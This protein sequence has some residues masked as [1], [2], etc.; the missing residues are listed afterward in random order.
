VTTESLAASE[1]GPLTYTFVIQQTS[2]LITTYQIEWVL[3]GPVA[4][5][6]TTWG[7]IKALYR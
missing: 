4:T 1:L 3:Q 5:E 7:S 2:A 6:P